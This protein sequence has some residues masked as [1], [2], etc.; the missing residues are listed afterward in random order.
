MSNDTTW[1]EQKPIL[2]V[3]TPTCKWSQLIALGGE[4]STQWIKNIEGVRYTAVIYL[5]TYS[6]IDGTRQCSN[7]WESVQN[8]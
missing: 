2:L 8:L 5:V 3:E 6:F 4:D 7:L 1:Y